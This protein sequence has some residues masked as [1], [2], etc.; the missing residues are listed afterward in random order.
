MPNIGGFILAAGEGRRLRP[1]TL[2]RPKALVPFCGVPLLELVASQLGTLDLCGTVVNVS[3]QADRVYEAARRLAGEN[4]W[5]LRISQENTL[6]ETGGG[7]RQGSRLIPDAEHILV[8]NVDIILDLALDELVQRHLESGAAVTAALVPGRGPATVTVRPDGAI[9]EF[10]NPSGTAPY[11]FSGVHL[12]RR[13]VL[14][15]LPD[16]GAWSIILAYQEAQRRGLPVQAFLLNEHHYWA[17]LGTARQYI[18]AHGEIADCALRYHPRLRAAQTEQARRRAALEQTGVICTGALGLGIDLSVPVGSQLHNAILWDYTRLPRPLL[19]ADGIFI[20]NDVPPA[21]ATGDER[22]PD[23][24]V[25]SFLGLKP[26]EC[27]LEPLKKQGS[28]RQ[29]WRL[30]CGDRTWVWCAYNPER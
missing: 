13:D 2:T 7:L 12:L 10:R 21:T 5:D 26:E 9:E 19:Y 29:Y 28:G 8:H 27:R 17:D 16:D 11:T 6:L 4:D 23:R 25:Y 24:R 1:A 18:R 3:Y 20:G 14:D 30:A 15:L 22:R